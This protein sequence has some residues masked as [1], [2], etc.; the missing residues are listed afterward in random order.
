MRLQLKALQRKIN[1]KKREIDD[2][3][4][5]ISL[6]IK[7]S[8]KRRERRARVAER[9]RKEILENHPLPSPDA[10]IAE[11]KASFDEIN[12]T[13]KNFC[14][15]VNNNTACSSLNNPEEDVWKKMLRLRLMEEESRCCRRKTAPAKMGSTNHENRSSSPMSDDVLELHPT[16]AY[17]LME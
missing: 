6:G 16:L 13:E 1:L 2:M 15:N 3:E 17:F 5:K 7:K 10:I 14:Q 8:R 12:I 9:K 11:V 4:K